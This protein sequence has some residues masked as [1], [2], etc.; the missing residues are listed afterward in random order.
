MAGCIAAGHTSE[1]PEQIRQGGVVLTI[2]CRVQAMPKLGFNSQ[3]VSGPLYGDDGNVRRPGLS[4]AFEP[5]VVDEPGV[6]AILKALRLANIQGFK[7]PRHAGDVPAGDVD[8]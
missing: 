4:S 7:P 1:V 5:V 2:A 3:A 8:G 6:Q